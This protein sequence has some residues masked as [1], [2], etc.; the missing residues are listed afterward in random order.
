MSS[1]FFARLYPDSSHHLTG[2]MDLE[3]FLKFAYY[4]CENL[5][6]G[7]GKGGKCVILIL[8]GHSSRWD[9]IAL[10]LFKEMQSARHRFQLDSVPVHYSVSLPCP[11]LPCPCPIECAIDGHFSTLANTRQQHDQESGCTSELHGTDSH[12]RPT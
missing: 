11:I 8:D 7:Y 6:E 12:P 9:P 1:R 4:F 3:N 5:P 10:Q 2:S